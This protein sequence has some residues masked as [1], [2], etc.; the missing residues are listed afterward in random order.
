MVKR[1]ENVIVA[2]DK[3]QA[4]QQMT[5]VLLKLPVFADSK[6]TLLHA[7]PPQISA[8]KMQAEWEQG[9]KLLAEALAGLSVKPGL[10]VTTQLVEGDPKLVVCEVADK[11][12][13]PLVVV[14]SRGLSRLS[15][16]LGNSVS[17]YVFQIASC[18]M[19]LVKDD[20]YVKQ[21]HRIM[22]A[23]NGTPAAQ[24]ALDLAMEM[25]RGIP[26][27]QLFIARVYLDAVAGEDPVLKQA[28][29]TAKRNGI[30]CKVFTAVGDPGM[31]LTR[32]GQESN[33][34]MLLLGSP[35]RRPTVARSLP[36]LDRLL[37]KSTSDYLRVHAECPVLMVRS[38]E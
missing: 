16:I 27:G 25:V 10:R 12:P 21:T 37:G 17:Q 2:V 26:G 24:Q 32:L 5:Q 29:A 3:T 7:V 18:P 8:D 28:E 6:I 33:A 23:L 31:Q 4:S 20:I 9:Q 34:D 22:V 38:R 13:N 35:D 19:L 36:D 11:T 14:G 30:N 15:A 1:F